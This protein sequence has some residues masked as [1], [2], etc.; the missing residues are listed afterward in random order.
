MKAKTTLA[1]AI[2][3]LIVPTLLTTGCSSTPS[4]ND[5][6]VA[7]PSIQQPVS[8]NISDS[9]AEIAV[10]EDHE[11]TNMDATL[12]AENTVIE[13]ISYSP[14]PTQVE[15]TEDT[16]D[17]LLLELAQ[18]EPERPAKTVFKFGFDKKEL[19]A[20]DMDIIIQHGRFLSQ[21]PDKRIQIHGHADAQ[22]NELYNKYLA[23]QRANYIA[24]LLQQ[25]GVRKD[26]IEIFSWGSDKPLQNATSYKDH[27]RVEMLYNESFMVQAS[28]ADPTEEV[29]TQ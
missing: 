4:S 13:E 6:S 28:E 20:E 21:H 27:R 10:V 25:Q 11:E 15:S 12:K 3:S 9:M 5:Y 18:V 17:G 7:E 29:I 1:A 2:A 22:G 8:E 23:S 16:E 26:Q 24:E 14:E 19:P